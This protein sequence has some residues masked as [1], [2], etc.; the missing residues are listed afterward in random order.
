MDLITD[1]PFSKRGHDAIVVFVDRLSKMVQAA[2][3]TKTGTAERLAKLFEQSYPKTSCLTG[4]SVF[5]VTFERN[6]IP[7]WAPSC[8]CLR[9]NICS[10]MG[11]RKG[12]MVR[13][14]LDVVEEM[15]SNI[16]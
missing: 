11:R 9:P 3:C 12:P 5:K 4:T 6:Y 8:P 2:P 16:A 7:T 13:S 14:M 15:H 10:P 1:H